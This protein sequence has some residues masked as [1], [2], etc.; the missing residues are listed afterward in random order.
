MK[1]AIRSQAHVCGWKRSCYHGT[2]VSILRHDCTKHTQDAMFGQREIHPTQQSQHWLHLSFT[3]NG[4]ILRVAFLVFCACKWIVLYQVSCESFGAK[5]IHARDK[6][7]GVRVVWH[8]N[9]QTGSIRSSGVRSAKL[10]SHLHNHS[11]HPHL[12]I[13]TCKNREEQMSVSHRQASTQV[14]NDRTTKSSAKLCP[15]HAGACNWVESMNNDQWLILRTWLNEMCCKK[16]ARIFSR[17]CSTPACVQQ[18]RTSSMTKKHKAT[19]TTNPDWKKYGIQTKDA[20]TDN[21]CRFF[22]LFLRGTLVFHMC[23]PNQSDCSDLLPPM[24]TEWSDRS[25]TDME[26]NRATIYLLLPSPHLFFVSCEAVLAMKHLH[27]IVAISCNSQC[28]V[29]R[30]DH[31]IHQSE[32]IQGS[33]GTQKVQTTTSRACPCNWKWISWG[34]VEGLCS[35]K[36]GKAC[37]VWGG[38]PWRLHT[39]QMQIQAIFPC[40]S[41][42]LSNGDCSWPNLAGRSRPKIKIMAYVCAPTCLQWK[43]TSCTLPSRKH[44]D[45]TGSENHHKVERHNNIFLPW[46]SQEK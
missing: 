12:K 35:S 3:A 30:C 14:A 7:A 21:A 18:P 13:L 17:S 37:R 42:L 33:K 34:N 24:A 22:F 23:T 27:E 26:M 39:R 15:T 4:I 29:G 38:S 46:A 10:K 8:K 28:C 19:K 5:S 31:C 11:I 16:I 40:S 45:T 25:N 32:R 20:P 9:K 6:L 1:V 2:R 44:P 43:R 41:K 36:Y